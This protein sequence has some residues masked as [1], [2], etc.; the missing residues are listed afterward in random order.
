MKQIIFLSILFHASTGFADD[1]Y[2]PFDPSQVETVSGRTLLHISYGIV[3]GLLALYWVYMEFQ[4]RKT[5]K[6]IS[7][8]ER[9]LK[10]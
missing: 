7:V 3:L 8:L 5:Q 9:E 1:G 10:Q 6:R 2:V 4:T